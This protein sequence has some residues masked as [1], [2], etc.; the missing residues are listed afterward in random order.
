M[1]GWSEPDP[2]LVQAQL[3]SRLPQS[4]FQIDMALVCSFIFIVSDICRTSQFLESGL[5]TWSCN[6]NLAY[7]TQQISC[8]SAHQVPRLIH[9]KSTTLVYL[10]IYSCYHQWFSCHR[11]YTC[12]CLDHKLQTTCGLTCMPMRTCKIFILLAAYCYSHQWIRQKVSWTSNYGSYQV[13]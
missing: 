8:H 13:P 5:T 12:T 4:S 6:N 9:W 7:N 10:A 11:S 2:T 3:F 1:R